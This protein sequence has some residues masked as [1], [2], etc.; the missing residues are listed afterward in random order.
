MLPQLLRALFRQRPHVG[1]RSELQAAGGARLD[2]GGLQPL[3]H[4]IRAERALVDLL[5]QRVEFRN[6]ERTARHAVLAA[7]AV[8]L[9]EVDDA[10]GVLDDGAVGR[11]GAEAARILAVHAL[12]LAHQPAERSVLTRM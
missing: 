8:L 1:L 6:V 5:R 7:D 9:L 12:I 3:P 2:A 4:S 11:A 10:V